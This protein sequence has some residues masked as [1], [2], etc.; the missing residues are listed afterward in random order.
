MQPCNTLSWW[1][2]HLLAWPE[3]QRAKCLWSHRQRQTCKPSLQPFQSQCKKL[4]TKM[5]K[6]ARNKPGSSILWG[7][8][9]QL[10]TTSVYLLLVQLGNQLESKQTNLSQLAAA[11]KNHYTPRTPN[12][13][14][15]RVVRAFAFFAHSRCA[16]RRQLSE[17]VACCSWGLLCDASH[18]IIWRPTRSD[19]LL[20][21]FKLVK[22]PKLPCF[23]SLFCC[24]LFCLQVPWTS[25]L[26]VLALRLHLLQLQP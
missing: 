13:A 7:L 3:N 9:E 21:W 17:S 18:N 22:L 20:S 10:Q 2:R 4:Q 11:T 12:S 16:A 24:C 23:L 25:A 26:L 15:F 8:S 5:H 1:V 6:H 19:P 14:P